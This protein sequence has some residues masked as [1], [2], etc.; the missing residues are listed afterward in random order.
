MKRGKSNRRLVFA[1]IGLAVI[2]VVVGAAVILTSGKLSY[3]DDTVEVEFIP[4][5]SATN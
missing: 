3:T 1:L 4:P 5:S 2:A